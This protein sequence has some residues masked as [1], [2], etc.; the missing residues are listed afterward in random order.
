M[1]SPTDDFPMMRL[2]PARHMYQ[3]QPTRV[4]PNQIATANHATLVASGNPTYSKLLTMHS[5][6]SAKHDTLM[7]AYMTLA[8]SIP[9]I[10]TLIPNPFQVPIP[11][12]AISANTP[13][14]P[15]SS[16]LLPPNVNQPPLLPP[17]FSL[18]PP[19]DRQK[20]LL[21]KYWDYKDYAGSG[22]DLTVVSDEKESKLDFLEYADG[23]PFSETDIAG[24]RRHI[25]GSFES[26][27]RSGL[28]PPTWRRASSMAVNWLRS[29]MLGYCPDLGLCSHYW[30]INSVAT[31]VYSQWSRKYRQELQPSQPMDLKRK[32]ES[33]ADVASDSTI[34][35]KKPKKSKTAS[36]DT[37]SATKPINIIKKRPKGKGLEKARPAESSSHVRSP[38]PPPH[39]T[40]A[41]DVTDSAPSNPSTIMP[42]SL[43]PAALASPPELELTGVAPSERSSIMSLSFNRDAPASPLQLPLTVPFTESAPKPPDNSALSSSSRPQPSTIQSVSSQPQQSARNVSHEPPSS[44]GSTSTPPALK[45]MNPL[46]DILYA[47]SHAT[48]VVQDAGSNNCISVNRYGAAHPHSIRSRSHA[49][50]YCFGITGLIAAWMRR[51]T[52]EQLV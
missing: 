33:D 15:S 42:S 21:V 1:S 11:A 37:D 46:I 43:D 6:L 5:E 10:F 3:Q 16:Q 13:M 29:E 24:I 52:G 41:L 20:F 32:L 22:S 35:T 28:A 31:E 34:S 2:P 19:L 7:D 50:G 4:I 27:L 47:V 26:L 14:L 49:Y 45:I 44:T 48:T 51:A 17:T 36:P 38:L 9:R 8:T 30:K 23:S 12:A 40:S 39:S 25:R 18:P